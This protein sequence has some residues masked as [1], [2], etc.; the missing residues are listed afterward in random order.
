L[1]STIVKPRAQSAS[2]HWREVTGDSGSTMAYR[3]PIPADNVPSTALRN[4]RRRAPLAG[5]SIFIHLWIVHN[6]I[7]D[8]Y[9]VRLLARAQYRLSTR[10][11]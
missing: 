2:M 8:N 1:L 6:G 7:V 11:G 3:R 9:E 10:G 5:G 4:R